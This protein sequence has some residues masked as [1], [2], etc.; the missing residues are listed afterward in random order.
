M[1]PDDCRRGQAERNRRLDKLLLSQ[2]LHL[3][4]HDARHGQPLHRADGQEEQQEVAPEDHHQQHD[5][6]HEGQRVENIHQ[7]HH[8]RVHTAADIACHSPP[9]HADQQ[10]HRGG[11]KTHRQGNAPAIEDL[12]KQI[13]TKNVGTQPVRRRGRRGPQVQVLVIVG[14][15]RDPGRQQ[16]QDH[17]TDQH[18]QAED[19]QAVATQANPGILPQGGALLHR[20]GLENRLIHLRPPR[21]GCADAGSARPPARRRP[22]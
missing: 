17:E 5:E 7:A 14:V 10:R 15:G 13:A 12:G 21:T 4:A 22:G 3:A 2:G 16:G 6:Y 19:R 9:G 1:A 8:D 18:H 11:D 20:A